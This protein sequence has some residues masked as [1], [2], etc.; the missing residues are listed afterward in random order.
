MILST[1]DNNVWHKRVRRTIMLSIA[2]NDG[3]DIFTFNINVQYMF[4]HTST[5]QLHIC[6]VTQLQDNYI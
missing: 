6:L 4:S 3:L 1:Y 5:Q 2:I